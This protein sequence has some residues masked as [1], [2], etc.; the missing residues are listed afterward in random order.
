MKLRNWFYQITATSTKRGV[1]FRKGDKPTQD[2]FKEL[3][4]SVVFKTETSDKAKEDDGSNASDLVGH[5]VLASN[6]QAKAHQV[7]KSDR[8]IVALPHQLPEI[9]EGT[10]IATHAYGS[11]NSSAVSVSVETGTEDSLKRNIYVVKGSDALLSWVV[12]AFNSVKNSIDSVIQSITTNSAQ[13]ATLSSQV[14]ALSAALEDVSDGTLDVTEITPIGTIFP[15]AGAAA[16]SSKFKI[17]NGEALD[18]TTYAT[19]FTV[20]G[21]N[22]SPFGLPD[23]TTFNIPDLRGRVIKGVDTTYLRGAANGADSVTL[24]A[25]QIPYHKHSL[26]AAEGASITVSDSGNHTHT[27][28]EYEDGNGRGGFEP[29]N[30]DNFNTTNTGESGSHVHTITGTTGNQ[31]AYTQVPVSLVEANLPLNYIIKVL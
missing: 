24:A 28:P 19:L 13:I 7:Q 11:L 20:L 21:G 29:N 16:P 3:T 1:R 15:Y 27:I 9:K 12:S 17:C 2:T 23:G 22:S 4:D 18:R 6:T 10:N 30:E 14:A 8:S 31:L 26:N 25:N 5:V